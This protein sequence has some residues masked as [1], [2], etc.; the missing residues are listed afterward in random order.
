[1]SGVGWS[2][3]AYTTA[4][5]DIIREQRRGGEGHFENVD[6]TVRRGVEAGVNY[7]APIVSRPSRPTRC[8]GRCSARIS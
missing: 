1:M 8:N 2:V 7:G 3:S 6:G 4:T 5:D